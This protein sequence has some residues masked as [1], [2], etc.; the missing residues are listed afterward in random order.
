MNNHSTSAW[1]VPTAPGSPAH[2]CIDMLADTS[3][4]V[5]SA[6]L[7]DPGALTGDGASEAVRRS[8]DQPPTYADAA[9]LGADAARCDV[10]LPELPGFDA[11]ARFV[12][13]KCS[14]TG[15]QVGCDDE[16]NGDRVGGESLLSVV[17]AQR[18]PD[19]VRRLVV[20]VQGVR[21]RAVV[22]N[23]SIDWDGFKRNVDALCK[24]RPRWNICTRR[25]AYPAF[26]NTVKYLRRI[27]VQGCGSDT[28]RETYLW[29][30]ARPWEP[31]IR[32]AA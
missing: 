3:R 20:D 23:H 31:M 5:S 24:R 27:V 14:H 32:V 11:E 25:S 16:C 30:L 21:L 7:R 6:P 18:F 8:P 15:T 1:L 29:N 2:Q 9:I 26:S 19:S 10:V 17:A 28:G 13:R 4:V 22:D 12:R